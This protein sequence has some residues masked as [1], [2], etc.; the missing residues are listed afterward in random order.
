MLCQWPLFHYINVPIEDVVTKLEPQWR[1]Y[2]EAN[3]RFAKAILKCYQPSDVVWIHDYHLM[4]APLYLRQSE[5]RMKI[6]WFLHTPFPSSEIYRASPYREELLHGVL[7][8]DLLGFHIFDY[9]R[10]FKS[11]C[12]RILGHEVTHQGVEH[13]GRFT[14]VLVSMGWHILS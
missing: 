8:A 12:T 6:G 5:P 14:Q 13:H 1:A 11:A 2:K 7:A 3:Q 10:H 9:A 4:L